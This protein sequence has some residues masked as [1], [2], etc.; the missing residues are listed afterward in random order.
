MIHAAGSIFPEALFETLMGEVLLSAT[1]AESINPAGY[2]VV[3]VTQAGSAETRTLANGREGQFL[4]IVNTAY[5]ADTVITP[6]SL[7]AGS[8]ITFN[9]AG[10]SWLGVFISGAWWTLAIGGSTGVA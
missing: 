3:N 10:D 2:C 7:G 9:A 6:A 8:A 5:A 1:D 4:F